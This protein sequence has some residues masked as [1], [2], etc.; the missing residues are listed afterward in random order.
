[1]RQHNYVEE[2]FSPKLCKKKQ[3]QFFFQ[4]LLGC[5]LIGGTLAIW[6]EEELQSDCRKTLPPIRLQP[7]KFGAESVFYIEKFIITIITHLDIP[8]R[9]LHSALFCEVEFLIITNSFQVLWLFITY[10]PT[11]LRLSRQNTD[12][13]GRG[14]REPYR[15][16]DRHRV[17]GETT[18]QELDKKK[19]RAYCI[20]PKFL[21]DKIFTYWSAGGGGTGLCWFILHKA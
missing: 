20:A 11:F 13:E 7:S 3:I 19:D 1:M 4:M 17:G 15:T 2:T 12:K 21:R 8:W 5:N 18:M 10:P 6:L 14:G 16:L 9:L